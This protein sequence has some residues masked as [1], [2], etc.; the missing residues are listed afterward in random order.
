M[1]HIQEPP[2]PALGAGSPK[3]VNS[4]LTMTIIIKCNTQHK[5]KCI[6]ILWKIKINYKENSNKKKLKNNNKGV[7]IK[8][9]DV[10]LP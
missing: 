9:K 10:C 8:I 5:N 4:L 6:I 7:I 1:E 3:Y 2:Q